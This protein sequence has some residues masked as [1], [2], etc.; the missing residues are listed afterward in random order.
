[1]PIQPPNTNMLSTPYVPDVGRTISNA[2]AIKNQRAR[3]ELNEMAIDAAPGEAKDAKAAASF[4]QRND[5]MKT[6]LS[7]DTAEGAVAAWSALMPDMEAPKFTFEGEDISIERA[8]GH[9]FS[10]KKEKVVAFLDYISKDP[11]LATPEGAKLIPMLAADAGISLEMQNAANKPTA[12]KAADDAAKAKDKADKKAEGHRTKR[13]ALTQDLA[14]YHKSE[15]M[16]TESFNK[17]SETMQKFVLMSKGGPGKKLD[18]EVKK[19]IIEELEQEIAY[20]EQNIPDFKKEDDPLGFR[21]GGSGGGAAGAPV[22][23]AQ[24]YDHKKMMQR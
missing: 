1:M 20:H 22:E 7:A 4:K 18:P 23:H 5:A 3:L 15:T 8:D 13:M 19:R 2:L 9:V 14:K 6:A 12:D 10:G 24:M 11:K 17:L 16:D 21:L